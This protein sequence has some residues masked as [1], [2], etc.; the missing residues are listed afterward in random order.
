MNSSPGRIWWRGKHARLNKQWR[1]SPACFPQGGGGQSHYG[2]D[3]DVRLQRPP[4]FS[5]AVSGVARTFGAH[6]QRTQLVPPPWYF[7]TLFLWSLPH[8]HPYSEFT[9][10]YLY[11]MILNT[12]LFNQYISHGVFWKWVTLMTRWGGGRGMGPLITWWEIRG[13]NGDTLTQWWIGTPWQR[14]KKLEITILMRWWGNW[15][16][17]MAQWKI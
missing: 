7:I 5:A 11:Y 1:C 16:P 9:H 13:H 12:A 6:G 15:G 10:V 3:V 14:D 8:I 2:G 4:I 17:L